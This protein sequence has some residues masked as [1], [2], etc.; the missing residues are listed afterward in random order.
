M[1]FYEKYNISIAI[2]LCFMLVAYL[3]AL[4]LSPPTSQ[5]W[6]IINEFIELAEIEKVPTYNDWSFGY[7]LKEKGFD[8]N[9]Y[10]GG[11]NPTYSELQRPFIALTHED[12]NQ[13]GC[14]RVE[15]Y[16]SFGRRASIYKC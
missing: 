13:L 9:S 7:W 4:W 1:S 11:S 3:T 5:D 10:G 8:T 12:L 6:F 14:E 2:V 15:H 16:A